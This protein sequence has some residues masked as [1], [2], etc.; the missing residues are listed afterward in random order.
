MN[1]VWNWELEAG[2]NKQEKESRELE[3]G[4]GMDGAGGYKQGAKSR[5]LK[6]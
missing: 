3:S 6:V 1:V 2:R 4:S 5:K